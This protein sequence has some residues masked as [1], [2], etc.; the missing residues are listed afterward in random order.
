MNW[1]VVAYL[2]LTYAVLAMAFVIVCY[3]LIIGCR[4]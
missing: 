4:P 3:P 2:L 1:R